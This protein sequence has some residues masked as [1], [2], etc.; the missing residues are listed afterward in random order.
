MGHLVLSKS[1]AG[2]PGVCTDP[3]RETVPRGGGPWNAQ[4]RPISPDLQVI[5]VLQAPQTKRKHAYGTRQPTQLT[6]RCANTVLCCPM[7]CALLVD[8]SMRRRGNA[9]T[10]T[11]DKQ[12]A[13]HR[14]TSRWPPAAASTSAVSPWAPVASILAPCSLLDITWMQTCTDASKRT[15]TQN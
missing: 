5:I 9:T 4:P 7:L 10:A 11:A 13:R 3:G 1:R 8:S 2:G 12:L 6:M 14:T 15:R